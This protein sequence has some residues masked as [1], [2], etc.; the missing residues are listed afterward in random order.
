MTNHSDPT[1]IGFAEILHAI[2]DVIAHIGETSP[3]DTNPEAYAACAPC[4]E[5]ELSVKEAA[6]RL[7]KSY[8]AFRLHAR[9]RS[10]PSRVVN[11][12]SGRRRLYRAADI[13]LQIGVALS[14]E[15]TCSVDV[16]SCSDDTGEKSCST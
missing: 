1:F 8:D 3:A 2:A 15:A 13:D 11:T 14:D 12:A 9:R 5:E 16:R 10:I 7:G 4:H 6:F